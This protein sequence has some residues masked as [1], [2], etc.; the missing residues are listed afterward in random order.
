MPA[1]LKFETSQVPQK[2]HKRKNAYQ[3]RSKIFSVHV[4][5]SENFV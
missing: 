4:F 1:I 3:S 5:S 2:S